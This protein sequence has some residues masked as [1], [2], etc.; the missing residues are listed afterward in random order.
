MEASTSQIVLV[1]LEKVLV[2]LAYDKPPAF[3][4]GHRV[5]LVSV[6]SLRE[7]MILLLRNDFHVIDC[8]DALRSLRFLFVLTSVVLLP[9]V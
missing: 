6:V 8:D 4:L 9:R 5:P 7:A 1:V 3:V 2:H